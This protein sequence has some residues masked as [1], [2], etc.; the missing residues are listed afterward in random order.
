MPRRFVFALAA[1]CLCLSAPSHAVTLDI[2]PNSAIG[3]VGSPFTVE[4]GILGLGGGTALGAFDINFNF[5]SALVNF[6]S[7]SFG[8]PHLGDQLD[9]SRLGINSPLAT[10][11]V[12]TVNLIETSF[13]DSAL[14]IQSQAVKFTLASLTFAGMSAGAA[15]FS[16]TIN[17]LS[18]AFGGP[19]TATATLGS[20]TIAAV[21][22][23]STWVLTL[24]GLGLVA[25]T[26]TRRRRTEMAQLAWGV[27][28]GRHRESG[29]LAHNM[30]NP[31]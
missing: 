14:L 6:Q 11:G 21:P 7:A 12:G 26:I 2:T 17:S 18:D 1:I 22:E 30:P 13:D 8:D 9:L 10:P 31:L 4:L 19:I 23:P 16:I 29:I 27:V 28:T 24:A 15:P 20:A 25:A 3:N 5:D